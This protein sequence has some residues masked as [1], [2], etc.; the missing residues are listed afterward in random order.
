VIVTVNVPAVVD[1]QD[2][3][4]VCGDGGS[5]KLGGVNEQ[6]APDGEDADDSPTVPANP[7]TPVTVTVEVAF[8]LPSA[9]AAPGA[10]AVIVKST[11]WNVTGLVEW[12]SVPLMPVTVTV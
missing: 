8:V 7:L 6:T 9:G 11:K 4:E 3:I 10:D 2:S 12:F 5:V 1:V